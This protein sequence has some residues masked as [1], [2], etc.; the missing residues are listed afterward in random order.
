MWNDNRKKIALQ[1]QRGNCDEKND[2]IHQINKISR[3]VCKNGMSFS[4]VIHR[5]EFHINW[6]VERPSTRW[7]RN[8]YEKLSVTLVHTWMK[9]KVEFIC[10]LISLLCILYRASS[11]IF[12]L[13]TIPYYTLAS[14]NE[15]TVVIEVMKFFSAVESS[16]YQENEERLT[17]AETPLGR[18]FPTN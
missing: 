14:H 13:F 3:K 1:R 6:N 15:D 12:I 9:C 7:A 8:K 17:K 10:F 16:K 5:K 11:Y 2:E 18:V 4:Q